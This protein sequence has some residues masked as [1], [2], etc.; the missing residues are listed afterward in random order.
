MRPARRRVLES[1]R[2]D[3]HRERARKNRGVYGAQESGDPPA[4]EGELR[5]RANPARRDRNPFDD[6]SPAEARLR[7]AHTVGLVPYWEIRFHAPDPAFHR[8]R[9]AARRAGVRPDH[10]VLDRAAVDDADPRRLVRIE[11]HQLGSRRDGLPG[12]RRRQPRARPARRASPP[13]PTTTTVPTSACPTP[14]ARPPTSSRRSRSSTRG[15]RPRTERR[16]SLPRRRSRSR[17][18]TARA[19]IR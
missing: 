19:P 18:S 15:T 4:R 7:P 16:T 17:S 12:R 3:A 14:S 6:P 13:R 2:L 1:R 8:R 11:R 10:R 5:D 9:D